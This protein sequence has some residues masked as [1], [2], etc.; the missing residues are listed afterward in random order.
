MGGSLEK[1]QP[2]RD[3]GRTAHGLRP[4]LLVAA[5]TAAMTALTTY[6]SLV[7]YAE[8]NSGW[9]WDIAYYNQWFWAITKGD[10]MMTV[11]PEAAYANPGPSVWKMIYVTALPFILIPLYAVFPDPTT[12][13]VSQNVVFWWCIPAGFRLA[14]E[15]SKSDGA[16]L[17]AAALIPATPLLWILVWNDFR[18]LQFAV[19]F[20][21]WAVDGVRGRNVWLSALGIGGMLSCRQEYA[22]VV[23]SLAFLP[24]RE[25]EELARTYR[26]ARVLLLLGL[27]WFFMV[28]F[29]FLRWMFTPS[30]PRLYFEQFGNRAPVFTKVWKGVE[31]LVIG[32]GPWA[33]LALFAPRAMILAMP[34]YWSLGSGLWWIDFM[35][36]ERWTLVRYATP[37]ASMLLAAGLIGFAKL[38]GRSGGRRRPL[39]VVW[40]V[41]LCGLLWARADLVGRLSRIPTPIARADAPELWEW[42]RRVRPDDGVL[43]TYRLSGPLSSRKLLYVY[44]MFDWNYPPGYPGRFGGGVD[45]VFWEA[46]DREPVHLTDQGFERVARLSSVSVYHRRRSPAAE[47]QE[48]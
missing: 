32:M 13:L 26:W 35:K 3:M 6:Q 5:L 24:A 22:I 48:R 17:L 47:G 11:L 33:V 12:L 20:V 44:N 1:I 38:V 34:W 29:G 46:R 16:A 2:G 36:D 9:S 27:A 8:F 31:V 39:A 42:I 10:R 30:T 43:T 15:E 25:P 21:L 40:G 45:W 41:S 28:F 23:A 7:R 19:P 4:W 18:E 37:G 14:R